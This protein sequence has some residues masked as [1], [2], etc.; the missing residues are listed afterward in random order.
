MRSLSHPLFFW[1]VFLL[2]LVAYS[3]PWVLTPD[4]GLNMGAYDLAEWASLHPAVRAAS[5]TLLVSFSLRLPL[6]LLAL[7]SA[8]SDGQ[9][10]SRWL[11]AVV[12]GLLSMALLPPLEFFTQ[13]REDPN[14]RQQFALAVLTL[15]GGSFGL[16]SYPDRWRGLIFIALTVL[17]GVSSLWG[18]WQGYTLLRDFHLPLNLG[19]GGTMLVLCFLVMA[20]LYRPVPFLHRKTNKVARA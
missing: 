13:Y 20:V 19:V 7:L 1:I 6:A 5:P 9:M 16:T 15:L 2:A 17:G 18:L 3:L 12:V 14:Y 11:R 10:R 4:T 8:F